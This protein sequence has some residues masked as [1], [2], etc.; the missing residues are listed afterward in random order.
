MDRVRIGDRWVGAGEK[1]FIVAE[2]GS[3]HDGKLAQAKRLIEVA[4]EAGCDA[5][6]FQTFKADK[7]VARVEDRPKYLDALAK[8]GETMHSL[9]QKLELPDDWHG[10]LRD[11]ARDH[12][13]V[14]Y[15]TP[16][17]EASVD[18]LEA[19]GVP[20][21]KVASFELNHL[22]LIEHIARKKRP[23][24]LSTGMADLSDVED[25]LAVV[26]P[27]HRDVLL[28]HCTSSYPA[29]VE[30]SN[31]RAME[32]LRRAFQVPVGLSD[33]SLGILVP[34]AAVALGACVIE[35]HFTVDKGLPGPDHPFAL[36][37]AELRDLVR[38]IRDVEAALGTGRKHRVAAEEELHRL[39][40]R[41]IFVV[42][43]VA[44]GQLIASDMIGILRGTDGI[45]P[46]HLK[47]VVGRRARRPIRAHTALTWDDL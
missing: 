23:M 45:E 16:F 6:K 5:V 29:K 1:C 31:L 9:F 12:G 44:E 15:S 19:L 36:D 18:M 7:I 24:I 10:E 30:D 25:A 27:H 26:Y 43:D 2:P 39:A 32:T 33:H 42:Q 20:C 22:P 13:L 3:N 37:P 46:K 17:D 4:A 28:L 47:A 34:A 35:K 41:R 14:F 21:F 11:H 40:R 8:P 38:S